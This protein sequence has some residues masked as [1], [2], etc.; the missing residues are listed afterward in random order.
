MKQGIDYSF[1][2]PSPQA[3]RRA[4]YSFVVRYLA[5]EGSGKALTRSE[6]GQLRAAGLDV[7]CVWQ[8]YGDWK[9]DLSGGRAKGAEHATRAAER[10]AACGGPAAAPI[11][12]AVDFDPRPA[13]LDTIAGYAQGVAQVLGLART[14]VYGGITTITHLFDQ[15]LITYGWQ[16]RAWSRGR[17]DDRAQLRQV[18]V[19]SRLDGAAVDLDTAHAPDFG[20]WDYAAV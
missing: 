5:P 18:E 3:V 8:A 4:G 13:Q 19:E 2:R 9:H 17:W 11:Y 10:L 20:Q 7:V 12:F 1:D 14:G 16:T 6:A 15:Q